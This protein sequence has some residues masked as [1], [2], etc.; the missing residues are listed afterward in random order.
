MKD[1]KRGTKRY[2]HADLKDGKKIGFN[3][4][5]QKH[6][7]YFGFLSSPIKLTECV[8]QKSTYS[9]NFEI[10]LRDQMKIQESPVKKFQIPQSSAAEYTSISKLPEMRNYDK[11]NQRF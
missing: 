10:N 8:V 9:G 1:P 5:Q 3:Q 4:E 2:F 7:E 11:I 6:I